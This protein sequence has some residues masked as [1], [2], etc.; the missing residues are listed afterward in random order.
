MGGGISK[1]AKQELVP[2]PLTAGRSAGRIS[3]LGPG[4]HL[5]PRTPTPAFRRGA[6]QVRRVDQH[7]CYRVPIPAECRRQRLHCRPHIYADLPATL[8]SSTARTSLA[9]QKVLQRQ[10]TT[11]C[12]P[13][14]LVQDRLQRPARFP[15]KFPQPGT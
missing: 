6:V 2:P 7:P 13:A 12:L 9:T 14:D 4:C 11:L 8:V 5:P 3:T 15:R 1:M 10:A